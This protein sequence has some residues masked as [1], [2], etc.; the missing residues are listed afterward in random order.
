MDFQPQPPESV[1]FVTLDSCRYDLFMESEAR[2]IKALGPVHRTMAPGNFTYSSHSAM[3][4]G[5]TPGDPQIKEP[6]FNPKFGKIFKMAGPAF[7]GKGGELFELHGRNIMDGF[8]NI[9]YHTIG[10]GAAGWF[11]NE[12]ETGKLLT[13]DFR[14]YFY[15]GNTFS[16]RRQ[17]AWI[18][19]ELSGATSPVFLFLNVGETHVPYYFDGAPWSPEI[20]PCIPFGTEND[21]DECVRR[22][23]GALAFVDRELHPLLDAFAKS[24]VFICSDHGDCWGEDGLWEH[25]IHHEKVYEVPLIIKPSPA[26]LGAIGSGSMRSHLH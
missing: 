6:W 23:Q 4:L 22:Q 2:N 19:G 14:S 5:F 13:E 9:G 11:D 3:F 26:L 24:T 7:P 16:L 25:G 8:E 21:R 15:A 18:A 1:L 17:L 10:T 12:T 20:N